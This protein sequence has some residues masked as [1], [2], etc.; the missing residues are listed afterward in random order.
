MTD[1]SKLLPT[2]A[3]YVRIPDVLN[4]RQMLEF[5]MQQFDCEFSVCERCGHQE[6]TK[7]DDSAQFLRE[8]LAEF[9]APSSNARQVTEKVIA[10]MLEN[11][12]HREMNNRPSKQLRKWAQALKAAGIDAVEG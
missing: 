7:D 5:L 2:E 10:E 11:C 4:D 8:Y 6:A 3:D 9:S 1:Q 12:R